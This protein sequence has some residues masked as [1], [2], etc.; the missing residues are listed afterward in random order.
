MVKMVKLVTGGKGTGKSKRMIQMANELSQVGKGHVVF[1]NEDRRPMYDLKYQ[2]RFVS[3]DEYPKF[4]ENRFLGFIYG[5]LSCNH[6]IEVIFIDGL[7]NIINIDFAGTLDFINTM[8]I[9]S[10]KF[11]IKVILSVSCD[12]EDLPEEY[13]EWVI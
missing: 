6:D 3:M 13:K 7:Q 2:I 8:D 5:I 11:Q 1:I 12:I 4:D 10:H 9:L